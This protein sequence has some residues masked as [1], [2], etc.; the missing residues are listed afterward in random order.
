[1][2]GFRIKQKKSLQSRDFVWLV[3]IVRNG[4]SFITDEKSGRDQIII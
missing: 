4:H 1:M 2:R 3:R